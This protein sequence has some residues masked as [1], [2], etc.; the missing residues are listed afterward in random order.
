MGWTFY[1]RPKGQTDRQHFEQEFSMFRNGTYEMVE[2]ASKNGVFY[3]AVRT[4]KEQSYSP[5]GEVWGLVILMQR[6]RGEHNFGYKDMT[7]TMG[8]GYYEAPARILDALTPTDNEYA[9]QWRAECRKHLTKRE[10]IKREVRPG[11]VV[12]LSKPVNFGDRHGTAS[13]FEYQ[14]DGRRTYW[15][16]LNAY[17]ERRFRCRLGADWA[18]RFEWK[19][20]TDA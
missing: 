9:L 2:T 4:L 7:E 8:P 12:E 10:T 13:R 17:N 14:Q 18:D 16:A 1:H 3:A 11:T 6:T 20:V 5:A 19:L 15:W